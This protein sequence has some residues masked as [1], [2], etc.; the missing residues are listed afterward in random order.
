MEHTYW[1]RQSDK[2]LFPDILWSRPESKSGSGKLAIIGGNSHGF[3]A[4]GIAYGSANSIGAGVVRVLLPDAVKKVVKGLLPD[5]DFAPSTPSGS[6]NKQALSDLLQLHNWAD[7]TLLAG[8]VG[9]NSETAILLEQFIQKSSGLLT[10]TQDAVDYFKEIPLQ[11]MDR[12]NT[13]IVLSIAQLQKMFINTPTITPI[14]LSMSAPQLAEAL[15]DYTLEHSATIVTK[16]N[17]LIFV[18]DK[19][20][21]SSTKNEE[22]IWRVMTAAKMSVFW[23]QNPDKVFESVTSALAI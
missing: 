22:K 14:T 23:M 2:P 15:H 17:D 5:A 13:L 11:I 16:H 18:A 3:G 1:L 4:P 19:G 12:E 9:R 20:R 21:V 7:C 8:D 6:F 10:I